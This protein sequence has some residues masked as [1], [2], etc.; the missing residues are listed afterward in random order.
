[1]MG[2]VVSA[3]GQPERGERRGNHENN[4][5][6]ELKSATRSET[7]D[8]QNRR[9]GGERNARITY[10]TRN[11]SVDKPQA[12]QEGASAK[13]R[14]EVIEHNQRR[15]YSVSGA[16]SGQQQKAAEQKGNIGQ[17]NNRT[18]EKKYY[19]NNNRSNRY[20]R[21]DQGRY[22]DNR[23]Y[24]HVPSRDH[25]NVWSNRNYSRQ[26]WEHRH[27]NWNERQWS[28]GSY[29][30]K[31]YIPYYFRDNRNYWYYPGYG[32]ILR[33][34][35]HEPVVLFSGAVPYYYEDGF[36]FR[37]YPGLGYVWIEEPYGL[38]FNELPHNAVRMRIGGKTYFR[39]G[40]TYF[41]FS[42]HGFRLVELPDR[43]YDPRLNRG[44]SFEV[45]ARF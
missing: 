21:E 44:V 34:F 9:S 4:S 6:S 28:F 14:M 29:Y 24:R 37:Y 25:Q 36:F 19:D 22:S 42:S 27:Y 32:H 43:Y 17:Q 11:H 18:T 39:F 1:M 30:K 26:E 20:N 33:G 41:R 7:V 38:W 15:S 35:R 13:N 45:S 40:N 31:G 8:N 2:A 16:P 23:D 5:S 10:E 12:V 3:T